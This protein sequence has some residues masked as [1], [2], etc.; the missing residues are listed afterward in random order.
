MNKRINLSKENKAKIISE[1]KR[2]FIEER[3]EE[4]GDLAADLMLDFIIEHIGPSIYNQGI[5]DS[6]LYM[7]E[8]VDDLYGLEI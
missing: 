2:Y 5:R 4:I 6:I 8:K 7:T 3:D 1:I